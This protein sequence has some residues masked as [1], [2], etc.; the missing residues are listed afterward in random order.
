[1]VRRNSVLIA[2]ALL[3][4]FAF[5]AVAGANN[6]TLVIGSGAEAI[7]LDPRLETDVPSFERI[8]VI[9]ESLVKFAVNMELQPALATEWEVSEDTM[10]LWFK[11][12]KALNGMTECPLQPKTSSIPMSG[13][14]I[15]PTELST[16][17]FMPT[18]AK[19]KWLM[20]TKSFSLKPTQCVSDEQYRPY[21]HHTKA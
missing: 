9:S 7:G 17:V 18:L 11:L 20:I 12:A 6:D 5:S 3:A 8:N 15:P 10:T 1:M 21:A 4:V 2:I 13:Y 16:W 14:L 19:L